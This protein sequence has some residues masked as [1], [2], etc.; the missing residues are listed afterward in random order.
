VTLLTPIAD[1]QGIKLI[2]EF[3]AGPPASL[4]TDRLR[5]KQVVINLLSNALKYNT[6]DGTVTIKGAK[7]DNGFLLLSLTDTGI[8]IP[9]GEQDNLFQMFH[10][11]GSDAMVAQEGAGIGLAVSKKLVEK[12]GGRIGFISEEGVGSTF[13]I[14][15]PLVSNDEALIWSD[16]LRVGVDAIDSDH[17]QILSLVNTLSQN[18]ISDE[19]L[20]TAIE[21]MMDYT[22]YHFAREEAIMEVCGY[23]D[24]VA[25][26]ERHHNLVAQ[27]NELA[28]AWHSSRTT[29]TM[30]KLRKFLRDWWLGHIVEVDTTI[31]LYTEGKD[32]D[33]RKVLADLE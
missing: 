19:E 24:L 32:E 18:L 13:W 6:N 8:G 1:K 17:Q 11:V 30:H 29:D 3:S 22:R 7:T 9:A 26:R 20:T 21:E 4:R 31:T 16:S 12:M 23:P 27:V 5:F 10:R 25:H 2:N 28:E 14:E 15:L 33:I